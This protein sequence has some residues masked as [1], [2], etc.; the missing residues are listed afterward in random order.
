MAIINQYASKKQV[1]HLY[2]SF[3]SDNSSF[4]TV[5]TSKKCDSEKLKTFFREHFKEKEEEF[6][7]P[8]PYFH[9][10]IDQNDGLVY[11]YYTNMQSHAKYHHV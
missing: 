1:E 6:A 11:K 3:K 2:R 8:V 7:D 4:E 5:K 9:R 10:K